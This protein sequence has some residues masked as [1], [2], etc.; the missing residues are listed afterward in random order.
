MVLQQS[1]V[2]EPAILCKKMQQQYAR[3][4]QR[5]YLEV[6]A[7]VSSSMVAGRILALVKGAATALTIELSFTLQGEAMDELPESLLG[8]VR[9][10]RCN[11][12]ALMEIEEHEKWLAETWL[13]QEE[14]AG[15]W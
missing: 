12:D 5:N 10:L 11:L 14:E 4:A 15:R 8:G 1:G 9:I 7:D 3:C 2:D 6:V 13:K